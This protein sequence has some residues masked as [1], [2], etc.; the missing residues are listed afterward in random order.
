MFKSVGG[1]GGSQNTFEKLPSVCILLQE[2]AFPGAAARSL[3]TDYIHPVFRFMLLDFICCTNVYHSSSMGWALCGTL[4]GINEK[5][6]FL[7]RRESPNLAT[8]QN[9]LWD[10]FQGPDH[11]SDLVFKWGPGISS[12]EKAPRDDCET[13][14][15]GA[16]NVIS[17][18]DRNSSFR[19][20][21]ISALM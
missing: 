16:H 4:A 11:G 6:H 15:S 13:W 5:T 3:N 9:Y 19:C 14:V 7:P 8:Y 20:S 10:R 2:A 18:T 21:G 1:T 17:G 12:F